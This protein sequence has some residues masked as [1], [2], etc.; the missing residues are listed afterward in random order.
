MPSA[1]YVTPFPAPQFTQRDAD[2]LFLR[3]MVAEGVS[4]WRRNAA[5]AAVRAAGWTYWNT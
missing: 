4:W 1:D 5:Y 3:L 2:D